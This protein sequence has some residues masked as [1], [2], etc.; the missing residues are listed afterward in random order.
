[1][2]IERKNNHILHSESGMYE[3]DL[4]RMSKS[5]KMALLHFLNDPCRGI[6]PKLDVLEDSG[7]KM[8]RCLKNAN[9]PI[10]F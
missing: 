2:M 1:M 8:V 4:V 3:H 10:A 7:K 5:K 6:V 9:V